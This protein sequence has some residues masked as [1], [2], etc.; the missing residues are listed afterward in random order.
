[1]NLP[2]M[3]I[4][5]DFILPPDKAELALLPLILTM[6]QLH[7]PYGTRIV[8]EL[9]LAHETYPGRVVLVPGEVFFYINL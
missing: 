5:A 6:Y 8:A 2:I 1:M 7:V 3:L 9:L 4:E